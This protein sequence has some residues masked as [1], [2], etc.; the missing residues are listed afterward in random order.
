MRSTRPRN[1]SK[2]RNKIMAR[3][4]RVRKAAFELYGTECSY[5]GGVIN[6]ECHHIVGKQGHP[7]YR[8]VLENIQPLCCHPY[9]EGGCHNRVERQPDF[10]RLVAEKLGWYERIEKMQTGEKITYIE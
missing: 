8:F 9:D 5:C 7:E 3:D 1:R 2:R 4:A 10:K 6:V